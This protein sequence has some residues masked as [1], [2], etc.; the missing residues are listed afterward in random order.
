MQKEV[1]MNRI[2]KR[3]TALAVAAAMA[4]APAMAVSAASGSEIETEVRGWFPNLSED[5]L[6]VIFEIED[7]IRNSPEDM[8]YLVEEILEY[9]SSVRSQDIYDP[10]RMVIAY[11]VFKGYLSRE[12]CLGA[13]MDGAVL[14]ETLAKLGVNVNALP[15]A[16]VQSA[17]A[18]RQD[19]KGWWVQRPD[20][21]YLV[22]E[23]Y[24]SNGLWYYMGA[25]GYML[26]NT[27]TPDG[28]KVNADGVWVQEQPESSAAQGSK[29]QELSEQY[30]DYVVLT[31]DA[32]EGEILVEMAN[33]VGLDCVVHQGMYLMSPEAYEEFDKLIS[34]G[35]FDQ[36]LADL[37][38]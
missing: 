36:Y 25:D 2:V 6:Q 33:I 35:Y 23:W 4:T 9:V 37:G 26:T 27:V 5:D 14:D 8:P 7:I 18:W 22:N 3:I 34:E 16:P 13:G 11:V 29:S 24:Q 1:M 31:S 17:P 38:I 20:G 10:E 19:A 12:Q 30:K 21:S 28:C 15:A 32:D